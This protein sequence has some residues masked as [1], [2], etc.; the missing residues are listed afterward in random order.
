MRSTGGNHSVLQR[1]RVHLAREGAC[2]GIEAIAPRRQVGRLLH[3]IK[4]ENGPPNRVQLQS[5]V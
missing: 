2:Y 3:A 4:S 5:Y 1:S